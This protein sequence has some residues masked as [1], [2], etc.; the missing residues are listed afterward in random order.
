MATR[1]TRLDSGALTSGQTSLLFTV[2]AGNTVILKSIYGY[3][4]AT[5]AGYFTLQLARPPAADQIILLVPLPAGA[6][7][8]WDG[9]A[10]LDGGTQ[11]RMY[12]GALAVMSYWMSGTLLP[13]DVPEGAISRP[14]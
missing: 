10:V 1:T 11:V 14:A 4:G 7:Y 6:A 13:G 9:W 8:R 12:N 2:P 5:T 3:T